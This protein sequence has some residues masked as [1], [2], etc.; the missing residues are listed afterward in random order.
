M[1]S[2][3]KVT[4]RK[5]YW[6]FIPMAMVVVWEIAYLWFGMNL[7]ETWFGVE[8]DVLAWYQPALLG[9]LLIVFVGYAV[10]AIRQKCWGELAIALIIVTVTLLNMSN[11]FVELLLQ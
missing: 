7:L 6:L 2:I 5:L 1:K 9:A 11:F 8:V 3:D 10:A 4:Q